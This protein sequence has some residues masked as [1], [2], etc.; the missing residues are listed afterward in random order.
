MGVFLC[1]QGK[2][3]IFK[4]CRAFSL[5]VELLGVS[6]CIQRRANIFKGCR[7][8]PLWVDLLGVFLCIQRK[9]H[10]FKGCRVSPLWVELLGVFL[11][12]QRKAHIFKGC[13]V[14]P[15][16]VE[17]LGV[18]LCVQRSFF[19]LGGVLGRLFSFVFREKP[20]FSKRA[21]LFSFGWN[22]RVL[23]FSPLVELLGVFLCIQRMAH[24]FRGC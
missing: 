6:L 24:I 18:F 13:R 16:W 12:I 19:P 9:A 4:G 3:N 8:S 7:V 17:L 2:A 22:Y 14:F 15:L 20:I 5:W 11:F 10:I 21:E 1:I 23:S